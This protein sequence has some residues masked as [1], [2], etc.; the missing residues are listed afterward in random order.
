MSIRCAKRKHDVALKRALDLHVVHAA[1][2]AARDHV[3]STD[4]DCIIYY[5]VCVAQ[6]SLSDDMSVATVCA[7]RCGHMWLALGVKLS[8]LAHRFEDT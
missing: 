3:T 4:K 5:G 1:S 6:Y 7:R 8:S 2:H